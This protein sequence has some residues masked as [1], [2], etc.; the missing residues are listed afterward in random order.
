MINRVL[1]ANNHAFNMRLDHVPGM[2][3]KDRGQGC[4]PTIIYNNVFEV[5]M[6]N[7]KGATSKVKVRVECRG[8]R[9]FKGTRTGDIAMN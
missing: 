8:F 6:K 5:E 9:N 4:P 1:R 3:R 7:G 2:S